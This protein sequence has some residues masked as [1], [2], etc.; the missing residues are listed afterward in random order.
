MY[1]GVGFVTVREAGGTAVSIIGTALLFGA[2]PRARRRV[3]GAHDPRD[4]PRAAPQPH[5]RVFTR[6]RRLIALF[7]QAALLAAVHHRRD[8]TDRFDEI[9]ESI[10]LRPG[11]RPRQRAG[12][13][14]S[15]SC[16]G[17]KEEQPP[18]LSTLSERAAR[19]WSGTT[20]PALPPRQ[21]ARR[22]RAGARRRSSRPSFRSEKASVTWPPRPPPPRPGRRWNLVG[23]YRVEEA[24]DRRGRDRRA[25]WMAR[26]RP[27]A[28]NRP[29]SV[30]LDPGVSL[31]PRPPRLRDLRVG[32]QSEGDRVDVVRQP[33]SPC[34]R[35]RDPRGCSTELG[36]GDR[37]DLAGEACITVE[38]RSC[39]HR[40]VGLS[41][42]QL[43]QVAA[44][45]R[46]PIEIG[47]T[48]P[49]SA[50]LS[51][52]SRACPRGR[53]SPGTASP[54]P[55]SCSSASEPVRF[56]RSDEPARNACGR[57]GQL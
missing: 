55:T 56:S 19:P 45:S 13:C 7:N 42:L 2:R 40:S 28:A 5:A 29:L 3:A 14:S 33:R 25:V 17:I 41:T 43:H 47:R 12:W 39:A 51:S 48:W 35:E 18:P 49:S 31:V 32:A 6:R 34:R 54:A 27:C 50:V 53:S 37:D 11:D 4:H 15:V 26:A 21:G 10:T 9:R 23:R 24:T 22:H 20:K 1:R 57:G 46:W 30:E 16:G 36:D 44:A 52:T 8:V 38:S